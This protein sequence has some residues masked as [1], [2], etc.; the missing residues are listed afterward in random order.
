M[1]ILP[2]PRTYEEDPTPVPVVP[3]TPQEQVVI[4]MSALHREVA[5]PGDINFLLRT[6]EGW[7]MGQSRRHP[8]FDKESGVQQADGSLLVLA[9][10]ICKVEGIQLLAGQDSVK[11]IMPRGD[12][13]PTQLRRV[14]M[15]DFAYDDKVDPELDKFSVMTKIVGEIAS[16]GR[17]KSSI[18]FDPQKDLLL[19]ATEGR[20]TYP[21]YIEKLSE[22]TEFETEVL[23]NIHLPTQQIA[24]KFSIAEVTVRTHFTNI[25][26]K[27]S[28]SVRDLILLSIGSGLS[29]IT[30]SEIREYREGKKKDLS[31]REQDVFSYLANNMSNQDM[32]EGL[33]LS[34]STVKT[35]INHI[36]QKLGVVDKG[37]RRCLLAAH[38]NGINIDI[39]LRW[40]TRPDVDD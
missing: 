28:P 33:G 3:V 21:A 29:T 22:L 26:K 18:A 8:V 1:T 15:V 7:D 39:P 20:S 25:Y 16:R 34:L 40:K 6:L 31:P 32:V 4:W 19:A 9:N 38:L 27:I 2:R 24:E 35:H 17:L 13:S 37:K 11:L 12:L 36:Y 23:A 10:G 30:Q 14:A 5:E